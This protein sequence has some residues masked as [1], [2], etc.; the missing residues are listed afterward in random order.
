MVV[1]PVDDSYAE[2]RPR[3]TVDGFQSAETG[4]Y[5]DHMVTGTLDVG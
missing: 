3:Q 4:S 2:R 1:A 5:H